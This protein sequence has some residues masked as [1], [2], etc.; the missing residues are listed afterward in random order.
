MKLHLILAIVLAFSI[1]SDCQNK[2]LYD[3]DS[4]IR[5]DGE[6]RTTFITPDFNLDYDKVINSPDQERNFDLRIGGD[7]RDN[8]IYNDKHN[9]KTKYKRFG[10]N[11]N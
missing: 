10:F 9:Q 7:Y 3:L 2:I 6:Y 4:Y 1:T 8:Q 5:V 11:L